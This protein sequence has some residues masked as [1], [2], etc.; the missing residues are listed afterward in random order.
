MLII[1]MFIVKK[2]SKVGTYLK[3]RTKMW[4]SMGHAYVQRT[5]P[6]EA[7]DYD[8]NISSPPSLCNYVIYL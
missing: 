3:T 8:H 6:S 7:D 4:H 2:N 1:I 5:S